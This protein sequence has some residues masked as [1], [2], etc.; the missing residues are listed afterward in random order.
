METANDQAFRKAYEDALP[1]LTFALHRLTSL[2]RDVA[3]ITEQL[4][5]ARIRMTEERVKSYS[6]LS[7]KAAERVNGFETLGIRI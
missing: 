5:L 1:G 3:G 4:R 2:V 7:R 6:S